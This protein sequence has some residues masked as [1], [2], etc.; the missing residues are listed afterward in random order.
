MKHEIVIAG[1]GT[2]IKLIV[3]SLKKLNQF[4]ILGYTD[5]EENNPVLGVPYLGKN[6]LLK[7]VLTDYPLCK[8]VIGTID[9]S[10]KN[11]RLEIYHMLK[12][13]GF[14][15]PVIISKDAIINEEVKIGEG[16]VILEKAMVNVCS[17]IGK[18][19]VIN[20]CAIV[21]HD[22]QVG[23]FVHM[24]SGSI[25]GG[26]VKVDRCSFIGVGAKVI[27]GKSVC[28]YCEIDAGS[29]VVK[30]ILF[31]GNYAGIPAKIIN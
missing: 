27:Q 2:G 25:I 7:D 26:G 22:C 28:S 1:G 11:K 16:S 3:N 14:E 19:V 20:T 15:L 8:A 17:S 9:Y 30:D 13:I 12:E 29:I 4:K 31:S 24:A 10:L 6:N 21:E 5:D 23:D 18:G